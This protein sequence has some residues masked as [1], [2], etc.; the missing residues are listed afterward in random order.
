MR[1]NPPFPYPL[2]HRSWSRIILHVTLLLNVSFLWP[3]PSTLDLQHKKISS[4]RHPAQPSYAPDPSIAQLDAQRASD[5]FH[6]RALVSISWR[7]FSPDASSYPLSSDN[8]RCRQ[9]FFAANRT[10][11]IGFLEKSRRSEKSHCWTL[12]FYLHPNSSP[13]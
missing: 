11:F 7:F 12:L 4:R 13:I 10:G 5:F 9:I 1:I 3:N 8:S 2:N 6:R